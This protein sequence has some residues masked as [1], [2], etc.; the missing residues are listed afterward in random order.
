MP[1][2]IPNKENKHAHINP[3]T[4][5]LRVRQLSQAQIQHNLHI[6]ELAALSHGTMIDLTDDGPPPPP[7]PTERQRRRQ[8]QKHIKRNNILQPRKKR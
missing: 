8:I 1:A 2:N 6:T 7:P 5:R 4:G 3:N